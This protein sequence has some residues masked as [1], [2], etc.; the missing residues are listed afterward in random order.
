MVAARTGWEIAGFQYKDIIDG[1]D[2]NRVVLQARAEHQR[3]HGASPPF[4]DI[5]GS[6]IRSVLLRTNE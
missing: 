2:W 4:N 3:A 5:C 6:C 1:I